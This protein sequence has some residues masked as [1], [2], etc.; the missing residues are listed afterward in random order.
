MHILAAHLPAVRLLLRVRGNSELERSALE[1]R[2]RIDEQFAYLVPQ[3]CHRGQPAHGRGS[4]ADQPRGL[5]HGQLAGEAGTDPKG[6]IDSPTL[7]AAI[8]D[9]LIDGLRSP[10]P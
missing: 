10:K 1:R 3:G 4:R 5:R 7:A 2:R 8:V 6:S 9:V